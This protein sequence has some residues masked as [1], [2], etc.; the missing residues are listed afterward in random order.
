M[1][2]L[3]TVTEHNGRPAINA[4][5]LHQRLEVGRDFSTW[6][7]D[8]IEKYEYVEG[9]DYHLP[10]FGEV[11][12]KSTGQANLII[13]KFGDN[14]VSSHGGRRKGA[15]RPEID[16]LLS[17]G[18]AKEIVTS[19]NNA[20][21][22]EIRR[23]LIKVEEAWNTPEAVRLRAMQMGVIPNPAL[24]PQI[25]GG[26][27]KS[28]ISHDY[29][30]MDALWLYSIGVISRKD[31][32][33]FRFGAAVEPSEDEL[34][35]DPLCLWWV[36][37][38]SAL[39]QIKSLP[40]TDFPLSGSKLEGILRG[41]NKSGSG[42]LVKQCS[43]DTP[44]EE[45]TSYSREAALFLADRYFEKYERRFEQDE[46]TR[47]PPV[48]KTYDQLKSN[49]QYVDQTETTPLYLWPP[50][51]HKEIEELRFLFEAGAYNAERVRAALFGGQAVGE[52]LPDPRLL[53]ITAKQ[54][55][56]G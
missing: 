21:S 50:K 22:L 37:Q 2:E 17:I 51:T 10:K 56:E 35:I 31:L 11:V 3:I 32:I 8:R 28:V 26:L 13:P 40:D 33:R 46:F 20:K 24:T 5:D 9:K 36:M 44:Y 6:I 54:G 15:G 43:Y 49:Y 47:F 7:K 55:I 1:N 38:I 4:R 39:R 18:T 19:E 45:N 41:K 23:Y 14:Q 48:K 25:T 53:S 34:R 52:A 42:M 29:T 27:N 12:N 16:Y 30:L